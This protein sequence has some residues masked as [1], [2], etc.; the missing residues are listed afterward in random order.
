MRP[1]SQRTEI[2]SSETV[3][4]ETLTDSPPQSLWHRVLDLK[5]RLQQ[6]SERPDLYAELALTYQELG[7]WREALACWERYLAMEPSGPLA[8]QGWAEWF[9]L[10]GCYLTKLRGLVAELRHPLVGI[11]R[12]AA[13]ELSL[14]HDPATS[15]ALQAAL[16]DPDPEVRGL[17]MLA[18]KRIRD[19]LRPPKR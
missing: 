3:T 19:E 14:Y 11:R 4:I 6:D 12:Q 16:Q 7:R 15:A 18:L 9:W 5:E 1:E 10:K 13:W 8:E 17:A 2:H